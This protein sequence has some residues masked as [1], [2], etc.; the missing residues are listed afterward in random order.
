MW[1]TVDDAA[2][3]T[4]HVRPPATDAWAPAQP[5]GGA[6]TS[7][8]TRRYLAFTLVVLVL[9]AAMG[10]YLLTRRDELVY[11][12]RL[13]I[14][15]LLITLLCQFT[16]QL[17][18]NG[19]MLLP[20]RRY[21]KLGY[22]ELFMVR[23]G[24]LLVGY[25]V[26]VA[27]GLGVRLAYLKA[28]GLPYADFTWAT[29]TTN[30]LGLAAAAA[31]AVIASGILWMLAGRLDVPAAQLTGAVA[32]LA[33]GGVAA[34]HFLPRLAGHTRFQRWRWLSGTSRHETSR[35][36]T[37]GVFALSFGRHALNFLSFGLLYQALL[38][39]PGEFLAGGLVYAITSPVRMIA[40][41]PGNIGVN[42]WVTAAVG[43]LLSFDLA[44]GL[45]VALVF[46]ATSLIAQGLGVVSAA[47]WLAF[48]G[49]A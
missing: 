39:A 16:S 20:L 25:G 9:L 23:T 6:A 19:A 14:P 40:V 8:W 5:A 41:T 13:S 22:W 11:I 35:R 4:R 33:L 42:E 37:T 36:T 28:R 31:L 17:F 26:P 7:R 46:R 47:A 45:I 48:R 27:G 30:V 44:T 10:A 43:K 32:I 24:G 49:E 1:K 18:W 21:V 3:D 34:L 38:R 15:I 29:M 12:R 2:G